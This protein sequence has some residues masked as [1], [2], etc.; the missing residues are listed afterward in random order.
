MHRG[1]EIVSKYEAQDIKVPYRTTQQAAGY[2]FDVL[3]TLRC[4]LFGGTTL[5]HAFK[6]LLAP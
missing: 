3:R 6:R 4:P 5:L 1:F 2:D